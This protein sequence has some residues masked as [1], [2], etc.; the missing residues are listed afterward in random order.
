MMT[1]DS[2]KIE[3]TTADAISAV[4]PVAIGIELKFDFR[5]S[6]TDGITMETGK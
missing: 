1:I 4:M 5:S 2:E 6:S 3:E